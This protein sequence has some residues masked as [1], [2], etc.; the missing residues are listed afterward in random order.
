MR[1]R[2]RT[3]F[4][5]L[6]RSYKAAALRPLLIGGMIT[7]VE[8]GDGGINADIG[9]QDF[10]LIAIDPW[11]GMR[12]NDHLDVYWDTDPV[13]IYDVLPED[14]NERIVLTV[15]GEYIKDGWVEKVFY[16]LTHA[17][18]GRSDDSGALRIKVKLQAPGGFDRHPALPGH[19]ELKA[20]VLPAD[21]V[22]NGVDAAWAQRGFPLVIET[23]P[24][25][26]ARDTISLA[27]GDVVIAHLVSEGEAAGDDPIE[28]PVDQATILAAGDSENLLVDYE[29]YD[30][31]YN[32]A[33]PRSMQTIVWVEAGAWRLEAPIIGN[34][35]PTI[36]L[37]DL[38]SDS[39]PVYI[40]V[41]GENFS[42]ED[43]VEMTW[44]DDDPAIEQP[45]FTYSFTVDNL[46]EIHQVNVPNVH[47]RALLGGKGRATYVLKKINGAPWLSSKRAT[48]SIV[49]QVPL[50]APNIIELIGDTLAPDEERAHV[51]IPNY[52][53]EIGDFIVLK[54]LGTQSNGST[55]LHEDTHNVTGN[56]AG[57]LERVYFPVM[58]EHISILNNGSL[59]V[60][61]SVSNDGWL[62]AD[63]RRSEHL[64]VKVGQ[65][66]ARL[67]A[68][69]IVEA[70]DGVLDPEQYP[71]SA[72]L[73]IA[74]DGTRAGDTITWY[75]KGISEE[76]SGTDSFPI[77]TG[78]AGKPL[79]F[80]IARALI[81]PNINNEVR[82]L[83]TL[84]R[85]ATGLFEFSATLNLVI[86]KL[87]GELP[88]PTVLEAGDDG[89]LDPMA[90][91]NGATIQVR[92][93]SM[94]AQDLLTHLW[95]GSPG[96]GTPADQ[97]KPGSDSGL[98]EF[99]VSAAVVGANIGREVS[100]SYRV[101]RYTAEKPSDVLRLPILP[102]GN[103][104]KDLPHPAINQA[105]SQTLT[106]NLATFTGNA[107]T[108]VAKW[109]FSAAG[110][111]VWLRLEGETGSGGL[112]AITLLDGAVLTSAQA[113][114][115]L[116]VTLPRTELEKLGQDT[117]LTVICN[118]AFDGIASESGVVPFPRVVYAFKLHHDWIKPQIASI[119]DGKGEVAD[120]GTTFDTALSISG[121]STLETELEILD[122][123]TRLTT[124]KSNSS[125]AWSG[126][127]QGL[128]VKSYS[129]TANALDGSGLVSSPRRLEVLA[130]VKPVINQVLDSRGPVS[131]GGTTVDTSLTISGKASPDR[132][133]ELFD[134][135]VSKG[136][137]NTNGSGEWSLTVS[138]LSVASH[139]FKAKAL[140]GTQP[141]SDVWTVNIAAAVAPT[142]THI[143]D[144]Q[145]AEIQ[146]DGF[147]VD[148]GVALTGTASAGLEVE[149]FDGAAS[150]QKV[151]AD[152]GGQWT[153]TLTG[154]SVARHDMK[155]RANYGSNPESAVRKFTVTAVV[156]PTITR[157]EDPQGNPVTNGGSTYANTVTASGKASVGQTVEVFDSGSSKGTASVNT[158]GDWSRSVSGL[159]VGAHSLT[160]RALYANNPVSSPWTLNVQAATAP[161]LSVR[162]SRGEISQGSTTTETTVTASGTAVANAQVEVFDKNASKGTTT[163]GGGGAWSLS[164][165][166]ALGSHSIKAVGKYADN[167]SS[168]TRDFNVVSPIPD[169]VLDTS[170][171]SLNGR[172]YRS[173]SDLSVDPQTWP[174]GTTAVRVP[175]SGAA[176]YSYTSSNPAI[177]R[178]GSDG[179]VYS[180]TNGSATITVRDSANQSGS[181]TVN[182]SG[183]VVV[184]TLSNSTYSQ[185]KKD[186][187]ANGKRLPN[188]SELQAIYDQYGYLRFPQSP[189]RMYSW[190]TDSV[191]LNRNSMKNLRTGQEAAGP[192]GLGHYANCNA[193]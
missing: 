95:L 186:A 17:D 91:L 25:R 147:T 111:R 159:S 83:Y 131:N 15:S 177:A 8:G 48:V 179:K 135:G 32:F 38:G 100:V 99:S 146:P 50:P 16:R 27:W 80:S 188:M 18:T 12:E 141:E 148:T 162:D 56:E 137:A 89:A 78:T 87:I 52:G 183:V 41:T 157:V 126:N 1:R 109:P 134:K 107:T 108:T 90:A 61:Y 2:L 110:Q 117:R 40:K 165:G 167:P 19:S 54:W 169:F 14:I 121:T 160:A 173:N 4:P 35:T 138:A 53:M 64:L 152:A 84:K 112:Y 60:S 151:T 171:V 20:P 156:T 127:L 190:S 191:G 65:H 76:G 118:V 133:I 104:D 129:L 168:G 26:M 182:V 161:T 44:R 184:Y 31:V 23:Y 176:P 46:S 49:G 66:A 163:A 120:G 143:R 77:T 158:S 79:D 37:E 51:E 47:I 13:A 170:P 24:D 125:G 7:P 172:L 11:Q 92:Y 72:T 59:D 106:L 94:E 82:V 3:L 128:T 45:A 10:V 29:V 124:V 139:A 75:W 116:S 33:T 192:I 81:E 164:V 69:T 187:A 185:A 174:T 88:A 6:D 150:R 155:V 21:I 181:Y 122:S 58:G 70:P 63:T 166:V 153:L 130:N 145:G 68:P 103:P 136:T 36:D 62:S 55:Y 74:Y 85:G 180:V 115:G 5:P 101:K 39:V 144:M 102:F 22:E 34:G 105:D 67:P 86:G 132:Q 142:I 28:I 30:E 119:K 57:G 96:A 71:D 97:E 93:A 178:V 193:I 113:S 149:I 43:V 42:L 175:S 9:C 114:D 154:L 140:Y 98:V 123:T 189:D 73:R